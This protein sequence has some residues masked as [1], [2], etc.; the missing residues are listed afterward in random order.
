[1]PNAQPEAAEQPEV[2]PRLRAIHERIERAGA[3]C[4]RDAAQVTLIGASKGVEPERLGKYLRAGLGDAGENYVAEG[5]AKIEQLGRQS[6]RW[7]CIG[8]LQSNKARAVAEHFDV[9]HSLD[10]PS[11]A[12]AL[13]RE[14]ERAGRTLQVLLQV[15][16]G[17]EESKSGCEPGEVFG[18]FQ[19]CAALPRLEISGL[20]TLGPPRPSAEAARPDFRELRGLRDA[21]RAR[22]G[23]AAQ[24]VTHLS[25]GMSGDFEV[26]IEEGA[27]MVRVGTALFGARAPRE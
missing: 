9:L 23:E 20:M 14:L 18:L 10:R 26:A 16:I 22:F 7:H 2:A 4:G 11:L 13:D 25:M 12:L 6:A 19:T 1:M 24:G 3:R 27:T 5:V 21:L 15:K 8:A 17:G